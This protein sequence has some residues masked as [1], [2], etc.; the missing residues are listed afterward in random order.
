MVEY[1]DLSQTVT[2]LLADTPRSKKE[3]V[4]DTFLRVYNSYPSYRSLTGDEYTLKMVEK[5]SDA[6]TQARALL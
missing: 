5:L 1:K 2:D 6:D 4:L 3:E